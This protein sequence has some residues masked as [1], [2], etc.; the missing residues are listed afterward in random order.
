MEQLKQLLK[1]PRKKS[2][3]SIG[4][5]LRDTGAMLYQLSCLYEALL[6]DRKQVKSEF[7]LYLL[8]EDSEKLQEHLLQNR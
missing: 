2:E 1:K 3:A 4:F 7:N 8:Y 6:E 5:D